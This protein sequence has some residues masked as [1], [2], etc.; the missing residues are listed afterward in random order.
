MRHLFLMFGMGIGF[1]IFLSV[2]YAVMG[3]VVGVIGAWVYN[4]LAKWI[5]GFEL[6]FEP[7]APP[8][9]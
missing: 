1:M 4:L 8:P 9:V 6:E 7:P 3:F 5:G 2:L